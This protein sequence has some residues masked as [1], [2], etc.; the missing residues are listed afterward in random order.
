MIKKYFKKYYSLTVCLLIVIQTPGFSQSILFGRLTTENG[1]SNN[2]VFAIVQ[3]HMGFLWFGTDDGLNRFDGYDFKVYRNEP[4]NPYSLSDNAIRSM[5]VDRSGYIWIGTKGGELNRY[6][7]ISDQFE[8]WEFEANGIKEN[9]ITSIYEDSKGDIWIGTYKEGLYKFHIDKK[10]FEHWVNLPDQENSLSI[11]YV[12]SILEDSRNELW[13]STFNGLNKYNSNNTEQPFTRIYNDNK[14][15]NSLSDNLIWTLQPSHFD[16]NIIWIGTLNGLTEFNSITGNFIRHSLPDKMQL[17]FG[18]SISSISEDI[19]G[20]EK[21]LWIGTFGGLIKMNITGGYSERFV[22]E[23]NNPFSI[24]SNQIHAL[25]KDKSGVLWIASDNGLNFFSHKSI[26][27][28][29]PYFSNISADQYIKLFRKIIN[30]ITRTENGKMWFGTSEGLYSIDESFF[31]KGINRGNTVNIHPEMKDINIWSLAPDESDNLWIGTYG[32]GLKQ[33]NPQTGKIISWEIGYKDY[34]LISPY[35]YIKSLCVSTDGMIWIGYWGG[36]V[37]R[38]NPRSG[39]YKIWRNEF[40][41]PGELSYN[42]V[43]VIHEDKLGRVWVGTNG[44]GLNLFEDSEDGY[45]HHWVEDK[46]RSTNGLNSNSIYT[47]HESRKS[48]N[49]S[50][51]LWIGTRNGLNKFV[52]DNNSSIDFANLKVQIKHYSV[53]DGLPDNSIESIVED[54]YGNLWI[55]TG[56]GISFLNDT[57]ERFINYSVSDGLVGNEFNTGSAFKNEKGLVLLGSTNGLNVFHPD[58]I[59]NSVYQPPV[60]IT[61]FLIFN[62]PV[63]PGENSPLKTN[64]FFAEQLELSYSQNVFSFQFAA[65]DFNSPQSNKYSY[66]MEGFDNDWIYSNSRRFVTYT[67]LDPGEY[68]FKIKATNSDGIWNENIRTLKVII[69]PPIWATWYAY[70]IYVIVFISILLLI[71]KYEIEKRAK[72]VRERLRQQKE[73]AEI[74]E[75]KLKTEAAELKAK[76]LEQEK[77]I[78]K[79]KIR[80]RIARDLHDEI[81]SNLSS[82]SLLSRLLKDET[83][84]KEEIEKGL[85]RIEATAKSSVISIRDIV[86]FINPSSDSVLEL[87][88]KMKESAENMLKDKEYIFNQ[89]GIN[90]NIKLS[91]ENKRAL[92]LMYKEVL[93]N[94]TKHSAANK[95]TIDVGIDSNYFNLTVTDNGKGFDTSKTSTGNGLRNIES[96]ASEINADFKIE[97]VINKGTVIKINLQIT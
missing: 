20:D 79:Q 97:S 44:G 24:N 53:K 32:Q 35:K 80:N 39:Q 42:D 84:S 8:Q 38:L 5:F 9:S 31:L 61:D 18:Y 70:T 60:H 7:P 72:R 29:Y 37:A 28:N 1:L 50:T 13:I 15:E 17:Q 62:Q 30:P 78:E 2:R 87:V 66:M 11:N 69:T 71:R 88:T 12:T 21:I 95:V 91:P 40:N 45:F 68:I 83:G 19:I 51:I 56:S 46:A 14:N 90:E 3:D 58:K 6:D 54:D 25:L 43:W 48:G 85:S 94:I 63:S 16:S 82:I 22:R 10:K 67:N 52:V 57:E 49:D 81:G 26:K 4:A 41:T 76:T 65:L 86:W 96:R 27:F 77:E 75:M 33:L 23:D 34:P 64:I 74:R 73:E 47:I 59:K 93:N 36:G 92:Y 55:G 89:S